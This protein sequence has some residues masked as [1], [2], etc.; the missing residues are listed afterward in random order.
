MAGSSCFYDATIYKSVDGQVTYSFGQVDLFNLDRLDF[1]KIVINGDVALGN[2]KGKPLPNFS[3]V[4]INGEFDCSSFAILPDSV[5]PAGITALRCLYSFNSLAVLKEILPS[6]VKTLYV[7]NAIINAVQKDEETLQIAQEFLSVFPELEVIGKTETLRLREV[8]QNKQSKEKKI[9]SSKSTARAVVKSVKE[10]TNSRIGFLSIA[11]AALRIKEF[12]EFQKIS[13]RDIKKQL[14]TFMYEHDDDVRWGNVQNYVLESTIPELVIELLKSADN[15]GGVVGENN[16]AQVETVEKKVEIKQEVEEVKKLEKTESEDLKPV[17]IKKFFDKRIWALVCKTVKSNKALLLKFLHNI[18]DVNL[19]PVQKDVRVGAGRVACVKKGELKLVPNLELKNS[20]YIAQGFG[21]DNNRPRVIW[22]VLQNG[23]WVA[24]AFYPN[25]GDGKNK[26]AYNSAI[27]SNALRDKTAA[28]FADNRQ[29]YIDVE[30]LLSDFMNENEKDLVD[31]KDG[32]KNIVPTPVVEVEEKNV[33]EPQVVSEPENI[34]AD[35]LN[36][37]KESVAPQSE[38]KKEEVASV[39]EPVPVLP[40]V[41][42]TVKPKRPRIRR[43][44]KGNTDVLPELE[45]SL[46]IYTKED[47]LYQMSYSFEDAFSLMNR[48]IFELKQKLMSETDTEKSLELAKQL[49]EKLQ[50]KQT[51]E[52]NMQVAKKTFD[53]FK[54]YMSIHMG[55]KKGKTL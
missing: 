41:K 47:I 40:E 20:C 32:K 55:R 50:D 3:K 44:I 11:D 49:S 23:E 54:Q 24:S 27:L 45:K 4:E 26:C 35:S 10:N 2:G 30:T 18:N 29:N 14:K 9:V 43:I 7:R 17:V 12:P 6:T 19:N 25:H 36:E 5:M 52:Q 34:S 42:E 51:I 37:V 22:C 15:A 8:I 1:D 38:A 16:V 39:S 21:R 46:E 13:I 48:D 53:L 33:V 31:T 28:N